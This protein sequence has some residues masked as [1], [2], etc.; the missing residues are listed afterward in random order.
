[1]IENECIIMCDRDVAGSSFILAGNHVA[2]NMHFNVFLAFN[3]IL[4][5]SAH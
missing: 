3:E 4:L 2:Y 1:M 5:T